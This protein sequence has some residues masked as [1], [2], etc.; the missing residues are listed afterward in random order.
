MTLG[1]RVSVVGV[2]LVLMLVGLPFFVHAQGQSIEKAYGDPLVID[3]VQAQESGDFLVTVKAE[4]INKVVHS[5]LMVQV[6]TTQPTAFQITVNGESCLTPLQ[7]IDAAPKISVILRFDCSNIITGDGFYAVS[8]TPDMPVTALSVWEELDYYP[9]IAP[10]LAKGGVVDSVTNV[11][12]IVNNPQIEVGGTDYQPGDNGRTFAILS[13]NGVDVSNATCFVKIY[14]PNNTLFVPN[15]AMSALDAGIYYYDF[16]VPSVIGVYIVDV[17]CTY[18]TGNLQLNATGGVRVLGAGSG[19]LSNTYLD[20]GSYWTDN[21]N[22][23][24]NHFIAVNFSFNGFN[25]SAGTLVSLDVLFNG[26]RPIV[27]LD[28][29]SDPIDLWIYNFNNNRF[30]LLG[31][32]FSYSA[33][34]ISTTYSLLTNITNYFNTTGGV[35]IYVNDSI[36]GL[37][38]IVNDVLSIDLLNVNLNYRIPNSTINEVSGGKELNVRRQLTDLLIGQA[39]INSTVNNISS[40]LVVLQ[41]GMNSTLGNLSLFQTL[42]SQ[43]NTTNNNISSLLMSNYNLL[44]SISAVGNQTLVGVQQINTTVNGIN[45]SLLVINTTINAVNTSIITL[46]NTLFF[47]QNQTQTSLSSINVTLVQNNNLLRIINATT[48]QTLF[49]V[50][51]FNLSTNSIISYLQSISEVTNQTNVT[52]NQ[53]FTLVNMTLIDEMENNN[54]LRQINGTVNDT[55]ITVKDIQQN[56]TL[57]RQTLQN[58]TVSIS[59]IQSSIT[60]VGI[61]VNDLQNSMIQIKNNLTYLT[62]LEFNESNNA[63]GGNFSMQLDQIQ[64]SINNNTMTLQQVNFTADTILTDLIIHMG[65]ENNSEGIE[66]SYLQNISMN[67]STVESMISAISFNGTATNLTALNDSI[68]GFIAAENAKPRTYNLTIVL[69]IFLVIILLGG[70]WIKERVFYIL[71][72]IY[73]LC[74]GLILVST[75][76]LWFFILMFILFISYV[77]GAIFEMKR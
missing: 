10:V 41:N 38:D 24:D 22:A 66:L 17:H 36:G 45:I 71:T 74:I 52:A 39:Q 12:F 43:I 48:N 72:G 77:Y 63:S 53:I 11:S 70:I 25:A 56:I 55:A 6:V 26:N 33:T 34:D 42:I 65:Q 68:T 69:L 59:S 30:E 60:A 73:A 62:S 58:I 27:A 18:L 1:R 8:V 3:A 76:G 49:L 7:K 14:Y 40:Q 46:N 21:E 35:V 16:T 57:I 44:N 29:A 15:T 54:Y 37:G 28:P 23:G 31:S 9:V 20:D 61:N 4:D 50:S 2:L 47:L 64:A 67:L 5:V 13:N 19:A 75:I 51:G 32:P